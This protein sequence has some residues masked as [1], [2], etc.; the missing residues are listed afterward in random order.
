MDDTLALILLV[1]VAIALMIFVP[2]FF[3]TR[4]F[5]KVIQIFRENNAIDEKNAKTID[6]LGL[7]P[8]TFVERLSRIRDYKPQALDLLRRADIV[9]VTEDGKLY[10]SEE[11][12]ASSGLRNR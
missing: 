8:P 11:K 3:I 10:L 12:L 7:T 9:Q 2:R 6:E 1:V 5:S 4:A